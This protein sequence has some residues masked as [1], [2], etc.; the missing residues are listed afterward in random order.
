MQPPLP[1]RVTEPEKELRFTRA[2]QATAFWV[3]TVVLL[4]T[5]AG[6]LLLGTAWITEWPDPFLSSPSRHSA[7]A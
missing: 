7:N 4:C 6:L 2:G 1:R 3:A 5:S